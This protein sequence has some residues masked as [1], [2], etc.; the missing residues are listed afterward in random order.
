MRLGEAAHNIIHGALDAFA[1]ID[2]NAALTILR[3]DFRIDRD[4][5]SFIRQSITYMMEDPRTIR[6]VFNSLWIGRSMERIGDH[7]KNICEYVIYLVY[8][9]DVRHARTDE[10]EKLMHAPSGHL[11]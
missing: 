5:E 1:R 3:E 9:K 6:R 11:K 7:A 2:A 4:Y 10:I 8:G